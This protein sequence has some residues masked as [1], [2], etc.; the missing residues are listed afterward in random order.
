MSET[1]ANNSTPLTVSVDSKKL[2]SNCER[3]DAPKE[4]LDLLKE[5]VP[6]DVATVGT[7][8]RKVPYFLTLLVSLTGYT[9]YMTTTYDKVKARF[10]TV[11]S[12]P[13]MKSKIV[14]LHRL[15]DGVKYENTMEV[16]DS[17]FIKDKWLPQAVRWAKYLLIN[18]K[19]R[20]FV[21]EKTYPAPLGQEYNWK[22]RLP[23]ASVF[24]KLK[25][26]FSSILGGTAE[27]PI[28]S[29]SVLNCTPAGR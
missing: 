11:I 9:W 19:G 12:C 27:S 22:C 23:N 26:W 7:L 25:W 14:L 24:S 8:V 20:R 5:Q 6:Q 3:A 13:E 10:T 18:D 4:V 16:L 1:T 17:A 15:S 28:V 29:G 21:F 2:W